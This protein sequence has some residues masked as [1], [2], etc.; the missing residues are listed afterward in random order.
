MIKIE[1][2]DKIFQDFK[3][4]DILIRFA[5]CKSNQCHLWWSSQLQLE[6]VLFLIYWETIMVSIKTGINIF[7]GTNN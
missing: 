4:E 7:H 6:Q 2:T 5:I 1:K 3:D